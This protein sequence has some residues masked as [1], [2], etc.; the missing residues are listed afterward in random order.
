MTANSR[1]SFSYGGIRFFLTVVQTASAAFFQE[2]T[3]EDMIG[4]VFGLF[5]SVN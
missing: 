2:D 1:L 4:S 3:R 5:G